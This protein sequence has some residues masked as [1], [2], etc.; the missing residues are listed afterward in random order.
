MY[1]DRLTKWGFKKNLRSGD[2]EAIV[3]LKVQR[4]AGGKQTKFVRNG[5]EV[6][7][8]RVV[9]HLSG[10]EIHTFSSRPSP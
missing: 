5:A 2:V 8:D 6:E 1:R 3:R 4:D 10:R 7:F 9:R